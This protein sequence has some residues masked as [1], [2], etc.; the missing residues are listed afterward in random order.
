MENTDKNK[1]NEFWEKHDEF[2]DKAYPYVLY[3]LMWV[4]LLY[5]V[6]IF[7]LT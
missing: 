7:K 1:N 4:Y 5:L 3:L 6:K 2:I